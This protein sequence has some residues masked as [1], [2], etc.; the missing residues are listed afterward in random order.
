MY[1]RN[2]DA[3]LVVFDV[4]SHE[5]F[6]RSKHWIEQLQTHAGAKIMLIYLLG[7][8]VDLVERRV[9]TQEAKVKIA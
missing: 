7:N 9:T 8:K 2:S 1:Y 3:A 4:T 6:E 5:S